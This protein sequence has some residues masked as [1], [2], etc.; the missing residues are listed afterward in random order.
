[1]GTYKG[2]VFI[3]TE[4]YAC[5]D[6][7]MDASIYPVFQLP[8]ARRAKCKPTS[9]MQARLNQRHAELELTRLAHA[10][11]SEGDVMLTLTYREQPESVAAAEQQLRNYL[12][13]VKRR[14]VKLGLAP[15]KYIY[16]TQRG[17]KYGRIHHHLM[18]NEGLDRD[19]VE[20]LWGLGYANAR[21]IQYDSV[22]GIVGLSIYMAKGSQTRADRD[23]YRRYTCSRNLVRPEP[24][25][26][27][28][29][30]TREDLEEMADAIDGS[31]A[32]DFFE[33]MFEGYTLASAT[34]VRN[35]ANKSEYVHVQMWRKKVRRR[36]SD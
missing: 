10:N 9:E 8:G 15:L 16:C 11:F 35:A 30:V 2:R 17:E 7:Y 6:G 20:G 19:E 4:I 22:Y 23:T 14:R 5:G 31:G 26:I 33:A 12:R 3:R 36:C 25:V 28:G 29:K 13:R 32:A 24:Q 34:A 27:D 21:R 18:L 1:M